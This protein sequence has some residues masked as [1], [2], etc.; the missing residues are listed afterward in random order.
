MNFNKNTYWFTFVLLSVSAFYCSSV[1][2]QIQ[3]GGPNGVVIGGG[4]GLRIGGRD[5]VQFG[6]GHGARFG[7]PNVGVQF[8]GGHGARFGPTGQGVQFGGRQGARFGPRVQFGG[9]MNPRSA[10]SFPRFSTSNTRLQPVGQSGRKIL[11]LPA[12]A[13]RPVTYSLNGTTFQLQP[14]REIDLQRNQQWTVKFSAGPNLPDRA[15]KI[16]RPGRYVF[17][18][19]DKGWNLVREEEAVTDPDGSPL[20]LEVAPD[21]PDS[22]LAP[23]IRKPAGKSRDDRKVEELPAPK[24]SSKRELKSVLEKSSSSNNKRQK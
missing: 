6:G 5:G 23:P 15:V 10:G 19:T 12:S 22:K 2:G 16:D 20:N 9:Q 24:K 13:K 3:I 1:E 21:E 14:G 11:F 7:P 17:G 8:G 18:V 4:L